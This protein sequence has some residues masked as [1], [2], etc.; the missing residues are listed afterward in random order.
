M[1]PHLNT[2][3]LHSARPQSHHYPPP[4]YFPAAMNRA[5]TETDHRHGHELFINCVAL[6]PL[7]S[8][9]NVHPLFLY[10][11]VPAGLIISFTDVAFPD[12]ILSLFYHLGTSCC[13]WVIGISL[14][15]TGFPDGIFNISYYSMQ[16]S[17]NNLTA[18]PFTGLLQSKAPRA[19]ARGI[20]GKAKRNSAEA[21]RLSILRSPSS[22]AGYCGGWTDYCGGRAP[23]GLRRGRL[24]P[25]LPVLPH[26]ASW[27]RRV[28]GTSRFF[29]FFMQNSGINL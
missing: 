8:Y 6:T 29:L 9:F 22:V 14:Y 23:I 12:I 28:K 2:P 25:F 4:I 13:F 1:S 27:R 16:D 19:S 18:S 10:T 7:F 3:L 20:S 26:G 21:T 5:P 15:T 17:G 24:T 11:G